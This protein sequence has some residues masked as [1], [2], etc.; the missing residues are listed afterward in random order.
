M[1]AIDEVHQRIPWR[2]GTFTPSGETT[3][4]EF[5]TGTLDWPAMHLARVGVPFE[6]LEPA[7]F[8]ETLRSFGARLAAA[9][10]AGT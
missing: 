7:D 5:T 3:I 9:A 4:L 10:V 2:G 1:A 6:V 8:R